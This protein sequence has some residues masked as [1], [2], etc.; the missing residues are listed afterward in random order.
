MRDDIWLKLRMLRVYK[1]QVRDVRCQGWRDAGPS[2]GLGQVQG[3]HGRDG[4]GE[5]REMIEVLNW[6][7]DHGFASFWICIGI[8]L[9]I[10]AARGK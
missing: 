8:I 6:I 3:C 10:E 2:Q 9:I 7:A 1:L 5:G 4:E